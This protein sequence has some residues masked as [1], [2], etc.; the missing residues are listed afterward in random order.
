MWVYCNIISKKLL[1]RKIMMAF[2]ICMFQVYNSMIYHA[3]SQTLSCRVINDTRGATITGTAADFAGGEKFWA[4]SPNI[5]SCGRRT[6]AD[7]DSVGIAIKFSHAKHSSVIIQS[8][9]HMK[10]HVPNKFYCK[11]VI[12]RQVPI[13]AIFVSALNDE[14]TYWRI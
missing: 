7:A 9:E 4:F 13:F 1:L 10:L 2:Y 6:E 11:L 14:F 3:I 8:F 12:I 5:F